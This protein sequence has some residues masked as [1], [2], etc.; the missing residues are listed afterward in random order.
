LID[1]ISAFGL[2]TSAHATIKKCVEMGRDLN[3]AQ[4][5]I[6]KY[7][8][9]EAELGFAKERKKK[10]IFGGVMD[11]AIEQHFKEEEQKRLKDELRSMFQ[12]YGSAGQWERLQATIARARKAHKEALEEQARKRD[13]IIKS[14]SIFLIVTIGGIAI[15]YWALYL[16]GDL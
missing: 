6:Q 7:A 11:N 3:S 16:K 2:I 8:Q 14:V 4:S 1:P 15:Y 10:G 12:L 9:G 13:I 5:A